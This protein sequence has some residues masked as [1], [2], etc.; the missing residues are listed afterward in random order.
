MTEHKGGGGRGSNFYREAGTGSHR[1]A[2]GHACTLIWERGPSCSS[3]SFAA[4]T[5]MQA[6][7]FLGGE[8][9]EEEEKEKRQ[10]S[11]H[12]PTQKEQ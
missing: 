11:P 12:T 9:E 4:H 2:V 3:P 6:R 5:H 8:K 10:P 7:A 1:A